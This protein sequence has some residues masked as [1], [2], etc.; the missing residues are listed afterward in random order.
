MNRHTNRHTDRLMKRQ[1]RKYTTMGRGGGRIV[2]SF[3]ITLICNGM[4]QCPGVS[5]G[6]SDAYGVVYV[7]ANMAGAP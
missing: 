3:S 1:S 5:I 6:G 7:H 4:N 2:R